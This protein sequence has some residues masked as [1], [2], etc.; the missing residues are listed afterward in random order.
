MSTETCRRTTQV[1]GIFTT[2]YRCNRSRWHRL[3]PWS[4]CHFG[5][6]KR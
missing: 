3:L 2:P 1:E 4:A 5:R 6:S